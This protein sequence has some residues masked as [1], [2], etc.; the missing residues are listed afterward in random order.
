MTGIDIRFTQ[1]AEAATEI[2][3]SAL[4]DAVL[5]HQDP[6]ISDGQSTTIT[7]KIKLTPIGPDHFPYELSA[8]TAFAGKKP[9]V[10]QFFATTDGT[11]VKLLEIG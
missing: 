5:H 10:N 3:A 1:L 9:F 7:L 6:R 2:I 8:T 11:D 4:K